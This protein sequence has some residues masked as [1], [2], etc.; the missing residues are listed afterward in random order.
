MALGMSQEKLGAALQLTFQQIQKYERGVNRVGASRLYDLCRIFDV[1]PDYFFE[2]LTD[3]EAKP[4]LRP[5][6]GPADLSFT[7]AEEQVGLTDEPEPLPADQAEL[8][9]YFSRIIDPEVRRRVL[10][11]VKS[12]SATAA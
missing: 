10:D 9:A 8:L 5:S 7:V 12:I 2:G 4:R 6:R 3:F 1:G 11:L